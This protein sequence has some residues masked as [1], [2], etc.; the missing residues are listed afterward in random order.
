[1]SV[2]RRVSSAL[3]LGVS[4]VG[5][6]VSPSSAVG[7]VDAGS[8]QDV[9]AAASAEPSKVLQIS[10]IPLPRD[11]KINSD[12][13]FVIG[14][15]DR[16]LGRVVLRSPLSAVDTYRHFFVGMPRTGWTLLSA[17]QGKVSSL[18]FSHDARIATVQVEGGALGAGA[19]VTIMVTPRQ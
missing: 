16:W 12:A 3:L 8:G 9:A 7:T 14:T 11:A 4:L 17:V 13:S 19:T 6:V 1:V 10:D 18:V 5:C 2:I 15:D